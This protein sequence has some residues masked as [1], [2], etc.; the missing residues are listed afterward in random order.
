ME[1]TR[2]LAIVILSTWVAMTVCMWFAA[3]GSFA[4]LN[5]ILRE[6]GSQFTEAAK[7]LTADQTRVLMRYLT[8]EINRSYFHAYGWAQLVL[9]GILLG[10]LLRQ[11]PRSSFNLVFAGAMLMLAAVLTLYITPEIVNLGRQ[12]DFVPR[13]PPPPEMGRFRTLHTVFTGLDGAKLLSGL[14][15]LGRLLL[16]R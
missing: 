7:P 10:L 12:M 6:S 16:P 1:R 5:R 15:L 8:S 2:L 14:V 11:V 3:S 13:N 9:G 4:T